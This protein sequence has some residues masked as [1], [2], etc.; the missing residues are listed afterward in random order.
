MLAQ[1][2]GMTVIGVTL[3]IP[4]A[5]PEHA[6]GVCE[7]LGIEHLV[8]DATALFE[9]CVMEQFAAKYAAGMTPN[10]C[11]RCNPLVKFR[12]LTEVA[13]EHGCERIVTGHYARACRIGDECH[14]L[15]AE[16]RSKDQSYMLYRLG[17]DVLRRLHLPMGVMTKDE[18]RRLAAQEEL[19]AA[20][21]S[22]SQDVCFV[23][24]EEVA[25]FVGR[26]RPEAVR[27]GP[28]LD[29]E[30][31]VLGE[32]R[33]L[34]H[35]TVGQRRGLGLGGPEGPYFVLRIVPE[36]NALIVGPEEALLVNE[37]ALEEV[38]LVG[39][40]PGR[41]FEAT[42]A[43]RYR[44]RETAAEIELVEAERAVVRFDSPHRAPAP[45][46]SAVFYDGERCIGGGIIS[47]QEPTSDRGHIA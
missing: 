30:G 42:V 46:Q 44:G 20:D 33:G 11:V 25:E 32:H 38:S 17:Q 40:V 19:P 8:V 22:E 7:A 34:A 24:D 28:I 1:R 41:H 31:E 43:T 9:R 6:A 15:R 36:R 45:G 10:P 23:S 26:R 4:G 18:A 27:P 21:R 16:D 29:T 13:E 47:L 12:V 2:R 35:Y 5:T 14:L 3:E 37:C 39:N